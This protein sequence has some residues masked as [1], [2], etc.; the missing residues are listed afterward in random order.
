MIFGKD[1]KEDSRPKKGGWAPGNYSNICRNGCGEHFIGDK[2]AFSCADCAYD[3]KPLTQYR[4]HVLGLEK[5]MEKLDPKE[6]DVKHLFAGDVYARE[7]LIPGGCTLTGKIHRYACINV[8]LKGSITVT[9]LGGVKRITGP[10]MFIS[11]PGTKR[12]GHAHTD[13]TW[14]TF[15]SSEQ[16]D[17]DKVEDEIIAKDFIDLDTPVDKLPPSK[18]LPHE[19]EIVLATLLEKLYRRGGQQEVNKRLLKLINLEVDNA[20]ATL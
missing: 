14:V 8:V 7:V 15:H 20:K 10:T 18:F 11:P 12:A 4:N 5:K 16:V 3:E 6:L 13:T 1:V 2:R 17:P 9:T 19:E